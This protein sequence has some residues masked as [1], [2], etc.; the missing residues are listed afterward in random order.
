ME[1]LKMKHL[2]F[3]MVLFI[4]GSTI[5]VGVSN[6]SSQDS[7]IAIILSVIMVIPVILMYARIISLNPE[8]SFFDI[9]V[10]LFGRI[11]GTIINILMIW[12]ALHL[13]TLVLCNFV[14]YTEMTTLQNTPGIII[15][16]FLLIVAV[17]IGKSTILT[18]GKWA[19]VALSII[20]FI[21]IITIFISIP[22]IHINHMFPIMD[23][24]VSTILIDS[25][26]NFAFPLAESVLFLCLG[27]FIKKEDSPYKLYRFGIMVGGIILLIIFLR[28]LTVLGI[29]M[30]N[31]TYFPSFIA[32]RV[33]GIGEFFTRIEG[34]ITINF[35]LAGIT[36]ISVC[37][38]VVAKGISKVINV[39]N[40]KDLII[41][42]CLLFLTLCSI[43]YESV[44]QMYDF[45]KV[46]A[47]Y[48][49]PFQVIIPLAMWIASEI[50]NRKEK[51]KTSHKLQTA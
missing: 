19:I 44:L 17:Y 2:K 15:S 10:K 3:L 9:S 31:D 32:V 12:Y 22:N 26:N 43:L 14:K 27:C 49:F 41:P 23:H 24:S 42:S 13:G 25:F 33:V 38:I 28:N 46:Y 48:S 39:E 7:W 47:I 35:I 51:R 21:I 16:I 11:I 34:V 50:R 1:K 4:I 45:L 6:N 5:I 20:V 18:F 37:L 36:K 29:Q 40:Y 30:L 8:E